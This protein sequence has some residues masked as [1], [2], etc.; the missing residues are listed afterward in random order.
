MPQELGLPKYLDKDTAPGTKIV[1]AGEYL[2]WS[3]SQKYR[4]NKQHRFAQLSDGQEV[5]L[6]GGQLT[7]NVDQGRIVEGGVYDITYE[8]KKEIEKGQW[9][10]SESHDYKIE[11]YSKA[12]VE[13]L[14]KEYGVELRGKSAAVSEPTLAP[15]ES[16]SASESLEGLE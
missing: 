1:V 3:F 16:A 10:G 2:G 8:G 9:A 15:M 12:E 11:V 5:I 6:G 14:L 7:W 13:T 4:N